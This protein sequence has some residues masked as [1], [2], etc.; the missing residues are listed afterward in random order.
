MICTMLFSCIA[1]EFE[2]IR[3]NSHVS[4]AEHSTSSL[5]IKATVDTHVEYR[6][7]LEGILDED[8]SFQGLL[9]FQ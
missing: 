4:H 2:A 5:R 6:K 9:E 8:A 1:W 3:K 7:I